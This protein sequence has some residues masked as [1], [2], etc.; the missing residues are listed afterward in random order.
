[1]SN[2]NP[3]QYFV[4]NYNLGK[5]FVFDEDWNQLSEKSSFPFVFY[6][7][8]V[9]NF[10]YITG[11]QN[12]WK[13]NEQLNVLFQYNSTGSIPGYSGLYYNL[14]NNLIYVAALSLQEIIVF[15]LDLTLT[16][17]IS[18]KPFSPW[19]I[20]GYSNQLYVG[21]GN[22]IMLVIE[23]KQIINQFNA[24]NNQS[25]TLLSILFDQFDNMATTCEGYQV[26]LY[27]TTGNYLNK[28]ISTVD[29]PYN[30]GFDSKS[31]F[32]VVTY[33]KISIFN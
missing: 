10:F 32:V 4:A 13:T 6:M 8:Q 14:L 25:A 26:Y 31:R 15:N 18:T 17:T 20:N 2:S 11:S 30:I 28:Y 27:N 3:V 5:I 1:M 22:R 33:S 19:S 21:T 23:N 24:C 29:F 12:L 9:G 7:I 16:D